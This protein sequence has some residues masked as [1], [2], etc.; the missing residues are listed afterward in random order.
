MLRVATL[1]LLLAAARA[2]AEPE[3]PHSASG[4]STQECY[5]WAADGQCIANPGFMHSSCKYSCWEWY[6][7]RKKKYPDAPIDKSMDCHNWANS[8]E[9]G[10]NPTYMKKTCPESCKEKG[11]DPPPPPASESTAPKKKKKKKG[12][13][14]ADKDEV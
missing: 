6:A 5:T 13:K 8:G 11:Y 2:D 1:C 7:H 9:C 14:P 3:N 4:D 12:K 10:K